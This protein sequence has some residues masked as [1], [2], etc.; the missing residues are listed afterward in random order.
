MGDML[1]KYLGG[2]FGQNLERQK[3]IVGFCKF[4]E[5]LQ[6]FKVKNAFN[7]I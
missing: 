3:K 4:K 5:N 7:M 2:S 6:G 1:E